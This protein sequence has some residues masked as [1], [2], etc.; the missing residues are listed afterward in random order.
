MAED[1][2]E[3]RV[4]SV[5]AD[6]PMTHRPSDL[7]RTVE[8]HGTIKVTSTRQL[9]ARSRKQRFSDL[10]ARYCADC[11]GA[12]IRYRRP[13]AR[14]SAGSRS[15]SARCRTSS[16]NT[17][18]ADRRL[19]KNESISEAHD[20]TIQIDACNRPDQFKLRNR[21]MMT[22]MISTA[23]TSQDHAHTSPYVRERLDNDNEEN[24]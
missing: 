8:M 5:C 4:D 7:R 6:V 2:S 21:T 1:K 11:G 17:S 13:C 24:D 22:T 20:D 10:V 3:N 12:S 15:S 9:F 16:R 19:R 23:S 18:I 14:I